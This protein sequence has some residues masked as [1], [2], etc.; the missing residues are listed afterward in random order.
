MSVRAPGGERGAVL[1]ETLVALAVLAA[2]AGGAVWMCAEWIR[3]VER[4]HRREADVRAAD[5]LLTAVSLWPRADLDRHLGERRQGSWIMRV[6][7][8]SPSIYMAT[9]RDTASGAVLLHTALLR[10]E[11]RP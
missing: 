8:P 1:L 6:D 3:A 10:P 5:R 9:L 7:R 11:P 2:A 4:A